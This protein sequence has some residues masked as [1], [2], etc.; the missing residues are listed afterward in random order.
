MRKMLYP[1]LLAAF[2]AACAGGD[3]E[4]VLRFSA[5]PGEDKTEMRAKFEPVAAYLADKLGVPVEYE[6]AADYQASVQMFKNG[7]VHLAWFG[8]LT[9][10]QARAAVAGSRAI[11]QGKEDPEYYSYFIAHASTGLERS[12]EFPAAIA[13]LR[14]TFGSESSTSGF[15]M[16]AH[17]IRKHS[18]KP[19]R[20]F[21]KRAPAFSLSH[22]NTARAVA[23]GG[24]IKA[25]ALSY[26]TY[27]KLVAEGKID[28]AVCRIIWKTP[29]YADYN[30][31]VHPDLDR[32]FGEGFTGRL[33]EALIAIDEPDLLAAFQRSALIAATNED[34]AEIKQ[35]ATELRM[36]R[37]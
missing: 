9:G 8:G 5:I 25:G 34:F 10:V 2:A 37:P 33:Q 3:Q 36:L 30:F 27:D 32:M 24:K 31:T 21:F 22:P 23:E 19:V 14:F 29:V 26:K 16:P 20:D 7:D 11:V 4:N 35:T 28:P 12:D 13:D 6:P 18:N 1:V 17:F 15:L